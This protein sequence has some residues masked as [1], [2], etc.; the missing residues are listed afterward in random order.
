MTP[1]EDYVIDFIGGV[2]E[3][4][5]SRRWILRTWVQRWGHWWK[6]LGDGVRRRGDDAD[7]DWGLMKALFGLGRFAENSKGM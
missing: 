1:D 4:C 7:E 6:I 5:G 3:R 2:R